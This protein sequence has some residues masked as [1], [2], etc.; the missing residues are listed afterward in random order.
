EVSDT[1][2]EVLERADVDAKVRQ[3]IWEDGQRLSIA[4]SAQRIQAEHPGYPVDLLEEHVIEWLEG[5]VAPPTYT[6]DQ[7]DEL[8]R[9]TELWV[10]HHRRQ[11]EAAKKPP[12][13]TV[14]ATDR[15]CAAGDLLVMT[16]GAMRK[17]RDECLDNSCTN[18]GDGIDDV[19]LHSNWQRRVVGNCRVR[20]IA[21]IR[22]ASVQ[23]RGKN[24]LDRSGGSRMLQCRALR[25]GES[26][27]NFGLHSALTQVLA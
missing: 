9:L 11:A 5:E 24:L 7:L 6:R 22:F 12:S 26:H 23:R 14:L 20:K 18:G 4:A 19:A 13:T 2:S 8:D 21:R 16:R 27:A 1:V 17:T 10:E 3:I 15:L 25:G